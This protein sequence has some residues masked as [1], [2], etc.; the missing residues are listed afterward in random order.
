MEPAL[1]FSRRPRA[2]FADGFVLGDPEAG[3]RAACRTRGVDPWQASQAAGEG[4]R[5]PRN[6]NRY[7]PGRRTWCSPYDWPERPSTTK[8]EQ[9]FR[10]PRLRRAK[11]VQRVF[12]TTR[13]RPCPT[14]GLRPPGLYIRTT[15]DSAYGLRLESGETS[16]RLPPIRRAR[17]CYKLLIPNQRRVRCPGAPGSPRGATGSALPHQRVRARRTSR[18]TWRAEAGPVSAKVQQPGQGNGELEP[19]PGLNLYDQINGPGTKFLRE[20]K[21]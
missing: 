9:I 7:Q 5:C 17:F 21:R 20:P 10:Q 14:D 4:L 1:T 2:R 18:P 3:R 8:T 12:G 11:P 15:L 16:G 13:K 6:W 19:E